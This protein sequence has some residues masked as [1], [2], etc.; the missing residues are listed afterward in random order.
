MYLCALVC[1]YGPVYVSCVY[2]QVM[3]MCVVMNVCV[4]VQ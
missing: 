2:G 4:C 3:C 1:M